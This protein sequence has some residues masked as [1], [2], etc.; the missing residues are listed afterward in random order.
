[1]IR[2]V[3]SFLELRSLLGRSFRKGVSRKVTGFLL[4][5][6]GRDRLRLEDGSYLTLE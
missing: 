4:L 5:G 1:M 2:G 6:V 3:K